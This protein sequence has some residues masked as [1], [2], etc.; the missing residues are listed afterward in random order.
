MAG[1]EIKARSMDSLPWCWA[2]LCVVIK[3][4]SSFGWDI[5]LTGNAQTE[6]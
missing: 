3:V 6:G 1:G 4:D 2:Q 5:M